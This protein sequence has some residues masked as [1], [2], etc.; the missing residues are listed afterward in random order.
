MAGNRYNMK[1]NTSDGNILDAGDFIAPQGASVLRVDTNYQSFQNTIPRTAAY[2]NGVT[3]YDG[4]LMIWASGE[5]SQ[6][7]ASTD[8]TITSVKLA[9]MNLKGVKGEAGG[10]AYGGYNDVTSTN[11]AP[12]AVS[13]NTASNPNCFCANFMSTNLNTFRLM[14]NNTTLRSNLVYLQITR[15]PANLHWELYLGITSSLSGELGFVFGSVS[16]FNPDN[17]ALQ[18]NE[19]NNTIRVYFQAFKT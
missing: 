3:L 12:L 10:S 18:S 19:G 17:I 1:V 14:N 9:N 16:G 13:V 4:E 11:T 15:N 5:C 8:D 6:V 7:T 2:P